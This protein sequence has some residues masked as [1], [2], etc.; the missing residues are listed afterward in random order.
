M[1]PFIP[2]TSHHWWFVKATGPNHVRTILTLSS[3][4]WPNTQPPNFTPVRIQNILRFFQSA[5]EIIKGLQFIKNT[6]ESTDIIIALK[7]WYY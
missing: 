4:H 2:S 6:L 3:I 7:L 1:Y 5:Q